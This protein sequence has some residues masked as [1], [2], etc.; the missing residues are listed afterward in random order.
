MKAPKAVKLPSGAW[1]CRIRLDGQDVSITRPTEK[2]AIAE[3]MAVKAGLRTE[4]RTAGRDRTLA[5]AIDT[6]IESNENV[7]S[8]ST[9]RGYTGYR[10]TRFQRYMRRKLSTM[11]AE[12]WQ[13]AVNAEAKEV[14]P[15]YLRNCWGLIHAAILFSTGQEIQVN[16]P[17]VAPKDLEFLDREQLTTFCAAIKGRKVEV[18]ALLAL[19]SLRR[20]EILA[21]TWDNIDLEKDIIHVRGAAVVDREQNLVQKPTNKN[22]TSTR[23]IPF[24]Y[25]QLSEALEAVPEGERQGLVCSMHFNAIRDSVNRICRNN[26]LPEIGVHG[27]RRSFATLCHG[28]GVP[29]HYTMVWGGWSNIQT[30]HKV[31]IK[32]DQQAGAEYAD[33]LKAVFQETP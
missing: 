29:E 3:A 30:V 5:Q 4:A 17:A 14:S 23:D 6:Y 27:L 8:P 26:G 13:K 18:P 15:K 9:I 19:E 33:K 25:P 21:L 1:R 28:L 11:T 20:S 12:Q 2:E 31:Y 16:L 7:L 10:R 24:I 22:K 32:L